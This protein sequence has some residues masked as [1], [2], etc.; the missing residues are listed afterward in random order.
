MCLSYE[1]GM[2][3]GNLHYKNPN[4]NNESLKAGILKVRTTLQACPHSGSL[5]SNQ[6]CAGRSFTSLERCFPEPLLQPH[7]WLL[8]AGCCTSL[9]SY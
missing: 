2:L 6:T 9:D 3:P 4:P 7:S 1:N 8:P 5:S